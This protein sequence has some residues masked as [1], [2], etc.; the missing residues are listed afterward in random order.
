MK[1][2]CSLYIKLEDIMCIHSLTDALK[3]CIKSP[4]ASGAFHF[5]TMTAQH[6]HRRKNYGPS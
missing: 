5:I 4:N 3:L 6:P 1:V 2:P